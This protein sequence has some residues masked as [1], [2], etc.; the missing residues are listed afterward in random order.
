MFSFWQKAELFAIVIGG[1]MVLT[2]YVG[3]FVEK[4]REQNDLV[5]LGL[6]LGSF[7]MV[8]ALLTA[9]LYYRFQTGVIS[10]PDELGLLAVTVLLSVTGYSWR[11]QAPAVFGGLGLTL[12]LLTLVGTLAYFP[13]VAIGVY[14]AI[15]GGL[16]FA[17]GIGLSIYRER[18]VQLPEKFANR[19]GIFQFLNWR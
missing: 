4:Q 10:L 7:L 12:Y 19:E 6:W 5:T 14:L 9:T 17:C 18:L 1:L 13:N 3:R 11:M 2:S 8:F 16:L 15:G